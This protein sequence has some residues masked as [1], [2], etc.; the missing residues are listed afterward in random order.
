[1][2]RAC[3]QLPHAAISPVLCR[4]SIVAV[5]ERK[6]LTRIT[7]SNEP[8]MADVG[9]TETQSHHGKISKAG[10]QAGPGEVISTIHCISLCMTQ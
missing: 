9:L 1:M 3:H 4:L 10:G 7:M 6:H 8:V 2:I 5:Y